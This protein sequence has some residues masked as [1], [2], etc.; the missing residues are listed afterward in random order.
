MEP[1]KNEA[2]TPVNLDPSPEKE[3]EKDPVRILPE[4]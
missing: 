1:V 2:V 4:A 3:P